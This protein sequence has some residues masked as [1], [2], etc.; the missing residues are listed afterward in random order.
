MRRICRASLFVGTEADDT[1]RARQPRSTPP[2]GCR[3]HRGGAACRGFEAVLVLALETH[4]FIA[5]L[6]AA[7]LHAGWNS[8][9]KVGLD[10]VSTVLLLALVQAAI[11]IPILPFVAQP[12]TQSWPWI[13][14]AAAL[15]TGYKIFLVK[16]YETADLSVA[17]P[18]ARGTAPLLVTLVSVLFLEVSLP[19]FSI[20]S[21][22]LISTGILLLAAKGAS[23][24]FIRGRPLFFALGTAAFTASYTLVDGVGARLA[25]TASGFILWMVVGDAIG[26][27][28]Y[29]ATSRGKA[30][31]HGLLPAWKT[32]TAAGAMS[33]ASYWIA[34][35]AF[36]QAPIALVAALRESSIVFAV[37]IAALILR[38]AVN[39]WRWASAALIALGVASMKM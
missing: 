37:L 2:E 15:H 8:V 38:E 29:A 27:V 19:A 36:T 5:V 24:S 7:A 13:I 1:T 26:M 12:A 31:L 10:R 14:A 34:V 20:L 11:G 39:P 17:Y 21:I 4:V 28:I 33:L 3:D 25:G 35:W 6:F 23:L 16:A 32:G 22:F 9:L 18:L 30:A